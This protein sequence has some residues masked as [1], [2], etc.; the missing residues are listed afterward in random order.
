LH[1]KP[2]TLN[3]VAYYLADKHLKL[4]QAEKW[5]TQAV[6]TEED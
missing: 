6:K 2:L 4:E 1:P 5:A 3:D